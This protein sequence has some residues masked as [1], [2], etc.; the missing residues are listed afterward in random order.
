MES[1]VDR[2]LRLHGHLILQIL[3]FWELQI[4]PHYLLCT[5]VVILLLFM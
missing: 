3:V 5:P 4:Y 1:H 2:Q